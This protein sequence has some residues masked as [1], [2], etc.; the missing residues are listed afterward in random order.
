MLYKFITYML[1]L[2]AFTAFTGC[3]D[4][5]TVIKYEKASTPLKCLRL[6]V[7]PP[8]KLL[9]ETLSKLYDFQD[10]CPYE[11]QASR[12]SGIVCN[13]NQNADKKALSNFPSGFIRLDVYK[14]RQ[15][16]YSYY[17]DLNSKATQQDIKKAF[18]RL[19]QDLLQ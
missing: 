13:S 17:K 2:A 14:S 10:K 6:V 19:S 18:E 5:A 8:D 7:F 16:I 3:S 9:F 1:P 11:L 15:P 12:K 4:N